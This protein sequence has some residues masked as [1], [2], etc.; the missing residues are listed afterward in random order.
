MYFMYMIGKSDPQCCFLQLTKNIYFF[1]TV[2]LVVIYVL[3]F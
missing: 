1:V 3:L 2:E